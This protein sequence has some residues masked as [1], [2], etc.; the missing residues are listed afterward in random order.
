MKP[1]NLNYATVVEAMADKLS[2]EPCLIYGDTVT[3]YREFDERSA[4]I[5]SILADHGL[6]K[7]SK[8]GLFLYNCKEYMEGTLAAFK[9]RAIPININYRYVGEELIYLL[10]DCDAEALVF[11]SSLGDRVNEIKAKLPKLKLLISVDDGGELLDGAISYEQI[12]QSAEP[13]ERIE[14][15]HLDTLML[16]TGGTTGMPKGV[17]YNVGDTLSSMAQLIPQF[18]GVKGA[19]SL[20]ELVE[21]AVER[22]E[23]HEIFVSLPASPLMHTAGIINSGI[24]SHLLGGA[25][26]ILESRSFDPRELWRAVE[27]HCVNHIVV[28]GD[29]F[30]K[31]MVQVIEQDEQKG[32]EYDISSLKIIFSSGVMFSKESKLKLLELGDILIID[33]AGAS[34]GGMAVQL[35]ARNNPPT[36]TGQFMALPTTQI[37]NENYE[38]LPR[39]CA[40]IG[41]IGM[42]GALPLG[43]YKD[44]SKSE[45]TFRIIDGKRFGFTG[46]M[47]SID[48]N[49]NLSF[50]GRGSHCI[51]TGGEKVFPEEV[52]EI[53]KAH[54][55]VRDC[56]VVGLPDDRFGQSVAGVVSL[57]SPLDS[58]TEELKEFGSASLARYKLPRI[59]T[60][61]DQI[62][63]AP[64]GKADYKWAKRV[65]EQ[66]KN[67]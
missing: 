18:L 30:V 53:I 5:S 33:A 39:G 55:Q 12:M 67:T 19:N 16:Y 44:T 34:E 6:Q 10:S 59:I 63:R 11:H 64:N 60:V 9:L 66:S 43:Y 23:H 65:L 52:E 15:S 35:S 28:V 46:D 29:T 41:L 49:G 37:F 54:P 36:D 27:K 51:N 38:M 4:R 25:L 58:P 32:I 8:V 42:G 24:Q 31:P 17:Q 50:M 1:M 62:Q 61:V 56:L 20:E 48:E 26:V 14:R 22:A 57:H 7:D 47:G 2:D 45:S 21:N 3:S 40:E 13:A